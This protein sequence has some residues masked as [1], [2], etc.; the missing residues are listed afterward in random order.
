[1]ETISYTRTLLP[2]GELFL[3]LNVSW[4]LQ[5]QQRQQQHRYP[6]VN[7][8]RSTDRSTLLYFQKSNR[9]S[10]QIK[11]VSYLELRPNKLI[12][13]FFFFFRWWSWS[14]GERDGRMDGCLHRRGLYRQPRISRLCVKYVRG[15][16]HHAEEEKEAAGDRSNR[17]AR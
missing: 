8:C 4:L 13:F 1:M 14:S 16:G 12:F 9:K 5:A 7:T 17:L 2:E 15:C 3:G 6:T 11:V 10:K